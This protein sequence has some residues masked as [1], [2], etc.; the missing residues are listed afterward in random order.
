MTEGAHPLDRAAELARREPVDSGRWEETAAGVMA[1]IR[2]TLRTGRPLRVPLPD[3]RGAATYVSERVVV[4][5]LRQAL[6]TDEDLA[7]SAVRLEVDGDRLAAVHV[8][9]VGRYGADLQVLAGRCRALV[10]EALAGLLLGAAD[11]VEVT[12]SVVD[13]TLDDPRR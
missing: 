5:V 13:V 7:P 3:D 1:R 8:D 10:G 6:S 2:S 9:L 4:A 12:M 11:A